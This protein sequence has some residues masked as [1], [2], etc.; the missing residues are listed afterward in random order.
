MF[1]FETAHPESGEA[2]EVAAVY[3]APWRG[4]RDVFG[5]PTEPDDI[6]AVHI[7]EVWD[8][9]GKPVDFRAFRAALEEEGFAF[10]REKGEFL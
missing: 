8:G 10:A 2:L 5:A 3:Y 7:C 4:L 1:W 6:E 9:E